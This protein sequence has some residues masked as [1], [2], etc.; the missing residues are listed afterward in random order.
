[1]GKEVHSCWLTTSLLLRSPAT[2]VPSA[3]QL[4]A[5][6]AQRLGG[7]GICQCLRSTRSLSIGS[8]LPT[9]LACVH[10][11]RGSIVRTPTSPRTVPARLPLLP[12][13]LLCASVVCPGALHTPFHLKLEGRSGIPIPEAPSEGYLMQRVG[14]LAVLCPSRSSLTVGELRTHVGLDHAHR[15]RCISS[16]GHASTHPPC[17]GRSQRASE[18]SCSFTATFHLALVLIS[19]LLLLRTR[20]KSVSSERDH[21]LRSLSPQRAARQETGQASRSRFPPLPNPPGCLSES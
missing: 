5:G 2:G 11:S 9:P 14:P 19:F 3:S 1:M 21:E 7:E 15:C 6:P 10:G 4:H 18:R 12:A 13:S 17:E 8:G 16:S 20:R